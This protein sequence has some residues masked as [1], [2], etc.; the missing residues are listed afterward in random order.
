MLSNDYNL[1]QL[2]LNILANKAIKAGAIDWSW[3]IDIGSS[4]IGA[5]SFYATGSPFFYLSLLFPANLFPMIIAWI[6]M[7]KYAV[8]GL[9]SYA[10]L[11]NNV[12][13]ERFAI[14]GSIL[15]AFSG[16]QATNMMFYH[17][18]DVV[19]FFPLLLIGLDIL[20]TKKKK[21]TFAIAVALCAVTNF[22]FF[23]SEVIFLVLYYL[24][25]YFKFSRSSIKEIIT[26]LLE[27][28]LGVLLAAVIFIPSVV[29]NMDNPR[30]SEF[31]PLAKWFSFERRTLL[32][33]FRVFTLPAGPM[34]PQAYI[35]ESDFSS[36]QAYLPMIGIV[37]TISYIWKNK[38]DWLSK[39]LIFCFLTSLFPILNSIFYLG[40]SNYHRWYFAFIL[41][42]VLASVRVL[43]DRKEYKLGLCSFIFSLLLIALYFGSK[44][45]DVNKFQ[46]IYDRCAFVTLFAIAIVGYLLTS[47]ITIIKKEKIYWL[48]ML[49]TIAA[50]ASLTTYNVVDSYSNSH[51]M[52]W[53][54]GNDGDVRYYER[55]LAYANYENP[56]EAFRFSGLDN[57]AFMVGNISGNAS[58]TS[59]VN[60]SIMELHE[61]ITEGRSVFT[62]YKD[63][64]LNERLSAKYYIAKGPKNDS[65][66]LVD[67]IK[68]ADVEEYVYERSGIL[69]IGYTYDTYITQDEVVTLT[70]E[71]KRMLMLQT[72]IIDSEDEAM[73]SGT[74]SH[75]DINN[76]IMDWDTLLCSW[77]DSHEAYSS[78]FIR[79]KRGFTSVIDSPRDSY[80]F[81]SVPNDR[82]FKAYV[83]GSE[84]PIVNINGLMAIKIPAGISEIEFINTNWYFRVGFIIS[85]LSFVV[86]LGWRRK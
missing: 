76:A 84:C 7:L 8:A 52:D 18:H 51:Y 19:A 74:L 55:L 3:N 6:F 63:T 85:V 20:I 29:F 26:C 9:T 2:P 67:T 35:I 16:F 77:A 60:G 49:V 75:F 22:Y 4:F 31:L 73:V 83:N 61:Q 27:G 32:Y 5:T 72:L 71:E 46:L 44:W 81:F 34:E 30:V 45:W 21:G 15:Y 17:F 59:T 37:P 36:W 23:V 11:K 70:N 66:I 65:D 54:H 50:F 53:A 48:A 62:P 13:S 43:E 38:K 64:G 12:K 24:F 80:A 28:V 68:Y 58:F 1:Q 78:E 10:Y 82:G 69:P 39:L 57:S 33:V 25:R 41:M 42:M 79:T 14:I 56:D 40:T 86:W 47:I